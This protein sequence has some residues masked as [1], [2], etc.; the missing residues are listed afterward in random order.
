M[1]DVLSSLSQQPPALSTERIV[2]RWRAGDGEAFGSLIQRLGP[3]LKVRIRW[4]AGWRVLARK[5]S[6][7]DLEHEVWARVLESGAEAY[8]SQ[9]KGSFMAWLG[10]LADCTLT[11]LQRFQSARKRG[12]ANLD[13]Q[14]ID[15]R[16]DREA[17]RLPGASPEPT[18]THDLRAAEIRSL[19]GS[20]L[21]ERERQIW[22]WVALD[23]YTAQEV[24]FGLST[25]SSSVRGVLL[26]SRKKLQDAL[27]G[28]D[29]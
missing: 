2:K 8:R 21:S 25:T 29:S 23:G 3:L 22:T 4:H 26:R 11:D 12:G 10:R 6:L 28:P 15:S 16:A 1:K 9:G 14:G 20:V 18:P 19:A 13:P 17:L 24:A 5:L 27:Q 7:E